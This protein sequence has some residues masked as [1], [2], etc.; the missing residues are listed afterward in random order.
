MRFILQQGHQHYE[1]DKEWDELLHLHITSI[2]KPLQDIIVEFPMLFNIIEPEYKID[3]AQPNRSGHTKRK[4]LQN[5]CGQHCTILL[6]LKLVDDVAHDSAPDRQLRNDLNTIII[7][8][9]RNDVHQR[10]RWAQNIV[11]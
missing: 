2:L 10:A 6:Q 5:R 3:L 7:L 1:E 9:C 8:E 4:T 11:I